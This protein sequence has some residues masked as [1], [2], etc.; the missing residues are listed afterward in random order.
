ML[1]AKDFLG[2]IIRNVHAAG[3]KLEAAGLNEAAAA[4]LPIGTADYPTPAAR[5]Q[6][7][8]LDKSKIKDTFGIHIPHWQDALRRCVARL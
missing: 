5:P 2:G 6:F 7:T 4:V 1:I 8:V 3:R